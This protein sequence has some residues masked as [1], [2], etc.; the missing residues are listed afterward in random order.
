MPRSTYSAAVTSLEEPCPTI[1]AGLKYFS[2]LC[3]LFLR[4]WWVFPVNIFA[5]VMSLEEHSPTIFA[6]A[7]L[8]FPYLCEL[9]LQ[10][11]WVFSV[12]YEAEIL[13]TAT[14]YPAD[15]FHNL[16]PLLRFLGGGGHFS[17]YVSQAATNRFMFQYRKAIFMIKNM[18]NAR[19]SSTC[20]CSWLINMGN[21]FFSLA[22]DDSFQTQPLS[23]N[24][25]LGLTFCKG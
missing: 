7:E 9:F 3:E 24:V 15:S 5:A 13:G 6:V 17:A 12:K 25:F 10:S 8:F 21:I 4:S 22:Q 18:T 11:C 23:S 19:P 16:R 2:Y 20:F 1:F 14:R